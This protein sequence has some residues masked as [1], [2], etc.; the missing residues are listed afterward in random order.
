MGHLSILLFSTSFSY[1][2][3]TDQRLRFMQGLR[4]TTDYDHRNLETI[5]I[6]AIRLKQAAWKPS[7]M[8]PSQAAN[9]S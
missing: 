3:D 4:Y 9:L 6:P 1:A 2:T 8:H 7:W 5:D